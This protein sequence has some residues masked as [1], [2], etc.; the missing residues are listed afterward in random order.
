MFMG[1]VKLVVV[2]MK[3]I[4]V[5]LNSSNKSIARKII[6][7]YPHSSYYSP[8]ILHCVYYIEI[9]TKNYKMSLSFIIAIYIYDSECHNC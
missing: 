3:N 8:Y 6:I 1:F 9:S 4:S 2:E 5:Y 7:I